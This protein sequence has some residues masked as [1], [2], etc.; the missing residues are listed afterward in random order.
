MMAGLQNWQSISIS[1]RLLGWFLVV[2]MIPLVVVLVL[3]QHFSQSTVTQAVLDH[4]DSLADT[5]RHQI[6]RFVEQ[7][8]SE[9]HEAMLNPLFA[10]EILAI[11]S[12]QHRGV[13]PPSSEQL[14]ALTREA[15][16]EDLLIFTSEGELLYSSM[17][18]FHSGQNLYDP[19][20]LGSYTAAAVD[21][22]RV[23]R[24]PQITPFDYPLALPQPPMFVTAP[25]LLHGSVFAVAAAR[26]DPAQLQSEI[27]D[28]SGLGQTGTVVLG[29]RV[30]DEIMIIGPLRQES[31]AAFQ[32]SIPMEDGPGR[33]LRRGVSGQNGSGESEDYRDIKVMAAW[34]DLPSLHW[35]MVVKMDKDEALAPVRHQEQLVITVGLA[36]LLLVTGLALLAAR[37]FTRP[38]RQLTAAVT[39]MTSGEMSVQVPVQS[40][41][42]LGELAQAF[43]SMSAELR[44]HYQ[45]V[46]MKVMRRTV[47]LEFTTREVERARDELRKFFQVVE[48]SPIS[49]V[50]TNAGGIIEYVN[51]HYT[52]STGY[53]FNE[54]V[55]KPMGNGELTADGTAM[56]DWKGVLSNQEWHG[57]VQSRRKSGEMYWES[58]SVS[59]VRQNDGRITHYVSVRD[60]I[61]HMK[62][63]QEHLL[64][65]KDAAE[66]ANNAKSEFL[67]IMSHEIRTPMNGILGMTQLVLQ[68]EM[69]AQQR[70]YLETIHHSSS[71][72]LTLLNDILDFSKLE[73]GRIDFEDTDFCMGGVT[74]S[75]LALMRP[76]AEEK[77]LSLGLTIAPEA[78]G[79][80][81]GDPTRLRQ[82]LL[83]LVGNAVKFTEHGGIT[84]HIQVEREEEN[85]AHLLFSVSDTGIGIPTDM[86]QRLFQSFTQADTSISRRYG[87]SGLGLAICRRLVELQDGSIGVESEPGQGSRF[88]FRLRYG[89]G[90][91]PAPEAENSL[92]MPNL[93]QLH[94]L[95][96]EDNPVNRKVA[97]AMLQKAGHSVTA[98]ENGQLALQAIESAGEKQPFDVVLMDVEM[99]VMN[100]LDATR[101]IRNIPNDAAK[102]PIVA[103]TANAMAADQQRCLDA[104][105]TDYLSKPID[106]ER[107]LWC[108][109]NAAQKQDSLT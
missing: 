51:P 24:L 55:G 15:R 27:D 49:V 109:A 20:F 68:T 35:G 87:G 23:S 101:A 63:R 65:T 93:P 52:R 50:I 82:I 79:Y 78:M 61:T 46:E 96:A 38:I 14:Q 28:P 108:L 43:N 75:V 17:P 42:E 86:R 37:S 29:Q 5:K 34:R 40:G 54:M 98:V 103:L 74:E 76:R 58:V 77:G 48:A 105:M 102:T 70:D 85:T 33:P 56:Q 57:E 44:D 66:S 36:T 59:P 92:I 11:K 81:H 19:P 31:L 60:D 22:A 18:D 39:G 69:T 41:D 97:T 62:V 95:L 104:G 9:L 91:A 84:I 30:S 16:F 67:A 3:L 2:S 99:P 25:L 107:L 53:G 80:F 71:A 88:W 83:N 10:E 32:K 8:R 89:H 6:E 21:R 26:I 4:L 72:L 94:V 90:K 1:S 106:Y 13:A 47:E 100:G 64:A 73:A 12:A 7:R 45:S